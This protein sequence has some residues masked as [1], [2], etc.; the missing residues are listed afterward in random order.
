ML[1]PLRLPQQSGLDFHSPDL[2][3]TTREKASTG[4]W[5]WPSDP[6]EG[7][8]RTAECQIVP[9]PSAVEFPKSQGSAAHGYPR[10]GWTEVFRTPASPSPPVRRDCLQRESHAGDKGGRRAGHAKEENRFVAGSA[11]DVLFVSVP[12][13]VPPPVS[14]SGRRGAMR[15]AAA[16]REVRGAWI[17]QR[18]ACLTRYCG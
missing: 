14:A 1:R 12:A 13:R 15:R 7:S 4:A 3:G 10:S 17:R 18:R 5:A 11:G 9:P 6:C 16:Q 2:F 8:N